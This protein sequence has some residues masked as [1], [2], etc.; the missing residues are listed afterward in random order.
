MESFETRLRKLTA[1]L[2]AVSQ[3]VQTLR[4]DMTNMSAE[5]NRLQAIQLQRITA[6]A[7]EELLKAN[8]DA[9]RDFQVHL[10]M[11]WSTQQ[12]RQ[13]IILCLCLCF[14]CVTARGKRGVLSRKKRKKI[15]GQGE[16]T[17][18]SV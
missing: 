10:Y 12:H 1:E 9:A 2:D 8:H 5:I 14:C 7:D 6:R 13:V 18:G 3:S 11:H 16:T 15:K 17:T 4:T